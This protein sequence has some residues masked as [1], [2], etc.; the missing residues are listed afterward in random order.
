ME[1]FDIWMNDNLL[2]YQEVA[3]PLIWKLSVTAFIP[4]NTLLAHRPL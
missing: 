2:F 3:D 4:D 1:G